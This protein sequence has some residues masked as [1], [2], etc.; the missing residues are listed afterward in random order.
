[1]IVSGPGTPLCGQL[2]ARRALGFFDTSLDT[3]AYLPSNAVVG[4]GA[5]AA[6]GI[7]KAQAMIVKSALA[8]PN[9]FPSAVTC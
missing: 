9:I 6:T 8:R 5:C 3:P 1:V 2:L 7:A 4:A